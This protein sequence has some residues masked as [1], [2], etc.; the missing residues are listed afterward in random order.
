MLQEFRGDGT[1]K[2][3]GGQN[4][5][6]GKWR[7]HLERL[8]GVCGEEQR[9]QLAPVWPGLGKGRGPTPPPHP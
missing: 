5:L 4:R 3:Q 8:A 6:Q 7:G 9:E 2:G 1:V